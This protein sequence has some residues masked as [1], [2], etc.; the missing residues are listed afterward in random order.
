MF[1][2]V[3]VS[4]REL[5]DVCFCLVWLVCVTTIAK[6]GTLVP[7]F[8]VS[9]SDGVFAILVPHSCVLT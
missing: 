1:V 4:M 6:D 8:C 9:A 5:V 3:V 2:V 7:P